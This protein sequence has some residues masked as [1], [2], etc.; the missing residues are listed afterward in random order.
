MTEASCSGSGSTDAPSADSKCDKKKSIDIFAPL[1]PP[2][3]NTGLPFPE[4]S[5]RHDTYEGVTLDVLGHPWHVENCEVLRPGSGSGAGAGAGVG[6]TSG[7][8]STT[9]K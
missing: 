7:S 5:L 6:A 8:A 4:S 3:H 2:E 9:R 1:H